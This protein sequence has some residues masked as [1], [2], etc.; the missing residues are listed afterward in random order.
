M[1]G[2]FVANEFLE[3]NRPEL[4]QERLPYFGKF[5]VEHGHLK[6]WGLWAE[7]SGLPMDVGH[8]FG[9]KMK[10]FVKTRNNSR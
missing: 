2:S 6:A 10:E 3:K 8:K 7:S 9:Q 1:L 4:V 5:V